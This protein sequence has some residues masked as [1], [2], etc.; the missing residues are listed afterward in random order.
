MTALLVGF[1][2]PGRTVKLH[3]AVSTAHATADLAE[4]V[5]HASVVVPRMMLT[6]IVL[7][8]ALG[9]IMLVTFCFCITDLEAQILSSTSVFPYVDIF[10][11]ATESPQGTIAMVSIITALSIC[12]N[13]SVV[14]A[15]S[16]QAWAFARDEGLPF[17]GWLRKV[18]S[19]GTPIPLRAI[20]V[21]LFITVVI[22]L[23]N[24]G[25]ATAFNSIVGLLA[26]S[27]GV[28][29]TI[30]IGCVLYRRIRGP[31]LPKSPFSLGKWV[32]SSP[33]FRCTHEAWLYLISR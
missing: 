9:F 31:P 3:S 11:S 25:S 5:R 6:T 28:S 27:G 4:E 29:Y 19:V 21:S 32:R 10:L 13:L 16:R 12:A 15:A 17:S 7:N 24:L 23:L 33:F 26:G 22:S 30:S 1:P 2:S 14:A 20:L 8:G 18:Q